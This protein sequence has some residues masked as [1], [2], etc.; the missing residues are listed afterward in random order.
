ML[1][2][3][4]FLFTT[5]GIARFLLAQTSIEA[6]STADLSFL[7]GEWA[8]VRVYNPHSDKQRKVHGTMVCKEALDAQF[9]KC[10]Y[11]IERTGKV[12]GFG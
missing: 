6:R 1:K 8:V 7:V 9:I 3:L 4:L 2:A 10:R 5:F 11:E 12:R